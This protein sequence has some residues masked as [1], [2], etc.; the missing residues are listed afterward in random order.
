MLT[1]I[2]SDG[3]IS[4]FAYAVKTRRQI[5]IYA[6][7]RLHFSRQRVATFPAVVSPSSSARRRSFS[8][9]TTIRL[10]QARRRSRSRHAVSLSRVLLSCRLIPSARR[11]LAVLLSA[12][13][14][15][16]CLLRC[17][18]SSFTLYHSKGIKRKCTF[19]FSLTRQTIV[20]SFNLNYINNTIV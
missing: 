8:H 3:R 20:I 6:R 17:L 5:L 19:I 1:C 7:Q 2:N 18:L 15:A 13:R 14:T 11:R 16:S 4:E 12:R 10:L 9:N